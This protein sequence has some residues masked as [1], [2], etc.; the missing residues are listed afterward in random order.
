MSINKYE[1]PG[2]NVTNRE[3][4]TTSLSMQE[5]LFSFRG[6]IGRKTYWMFFLGMFIAFFALAFVVSFLGLDESTL[7]I[8]I[9]VAYIPV[10]WMSLA[11]QVKRWHDR[12]KSGWWVLIA[13]IPIVGSIWVLV[14]NGFLAGTEGRN[15]FGFPNV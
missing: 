3:Y 2:S 13:L 12:D 8:V 11:V 4:G 1:A 9:V 7:T 6:R 15:R 5:I 10:I 14:E